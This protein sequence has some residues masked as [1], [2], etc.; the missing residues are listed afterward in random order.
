MSREE[1]TAI[2]ADQA[3][4]IVSRFKGCP[5]YIWGSGQH[6]K[7]LVEHIGEKILGFIDS[8]PLKQGASIS[9]YQVIAPEDVCRY[10]ENKVIISVTSDY[11]SIASYLSSIGMK[12]GL[13]YVVAFPLAK[14]QY[15]FSKTDSYIQRVGKYDFTG[16][17]LLEVGYGGQLYLA[18]LFAFLGAEKVYVS[19]IV[20]HSADVKK[21]A[22]PK[23]KQYIKYLVDSYP[24]RCDSD[25][26]LQHLLDKIQN[27]I[28]IVSEPCVAEEL[29]FDDSELDGIY[30]SGVMEHVNDPDKAFEEFGRVIKPGG[31]AMCLDIGVNDHRANDP[32]SGYNVWSYFEIPDTVWNTYTNNAYHQNRWLGVDFKRE[33]AAKGFEIVHYDADKDYSLSKEQ[34]ERFDSR[35][36]VY[37]YDD[38]ID[39]YPWVIGRREN[40]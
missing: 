29:P 14:L 26:T 8:N 36:R 39:V 18:S 28:E 10:K 30:S 7:W 6:G 5:V 25:Y 15:L 16:K 9:S 34:I 38:L 33:L 20:E 2:L 4:E 32:T 11:E 37:D 12:E 24:N 17:T 1:I 13:N 21:N 27:S 35:F 23:L 19:D 22:E 40:L 31:L 3:R